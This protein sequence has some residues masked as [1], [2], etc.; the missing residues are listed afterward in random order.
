LPKLGF[1]VWKETIWQ[2]CS[3]RKIK[4]NP[5]SEKWELAENRK[6][7]ET[8]NRWKPLPRTKLNAAFSQGFQDKI[9]FI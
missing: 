2:P 7:V 1:L 3:Q 6:P 4:L 8:R 9:G 5:T